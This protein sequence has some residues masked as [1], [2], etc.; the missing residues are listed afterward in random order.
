[1]SGCHCTKNRVYRLLSKSTLDPGVPANTGVHCREAFH[2]IGEA[3]A[4]SVRDEGGN[5]E[6]AIRTAF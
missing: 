3:R 5:R 1:M 2:S 6:E 4:M